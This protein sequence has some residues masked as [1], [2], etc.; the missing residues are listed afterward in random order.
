M[1]EIKKGDS[2]ICRAR[3][4]NTFFSRFRGLMFKRELSKEEG[5][6]I[7]FSKRLGSQS[8]HGFFMRFPLDLVFIDGEKKIV[9]LASLHPYRL[10]SP[11]KKS[12]WVLEVNK[13][14]VKKNGLTIGDRLQF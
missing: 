10:Y 14:F 9:E 12:F 13:G 1:I 7:E 4:A 6:L 3:V 2:S 8:I 11:K 5:F